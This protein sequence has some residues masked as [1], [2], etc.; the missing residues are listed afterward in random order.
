MTMREHIEAAA[1]L[2][3]EAMAELAQS[4][5]ELAAANWQAWEV[6]SQTN[7]QIAEKRLDKTRELV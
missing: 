6:T 5:D 4:L 7:G 3:T 2:V 1:E